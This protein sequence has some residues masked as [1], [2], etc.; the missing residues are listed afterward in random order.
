LIPIAVILLLLFGIAAV[1]VLFKQ[2]IVPGGFI[3]ECGACKYTLVGLPEG[4][5][6]PECGGRTL[7]RLPDRKEWVVTPV[8]QSVLWTSFA[9]L[10][11]AAAAFHSCGTYLQMLSYRREGFSEITARHMVLHVGRDEPSGTIVTLALFLPLTL[12][13]TCTP[14]IA[15]V[16]SHSKSWRMW[17]LLLLSALIGSALIALAYGWRGTSVLQK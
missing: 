14:L 5:V 15:I 11:V 1:C 12:F 6:C 16:E 3:P 4:S 2:R 9:L 17:R 8:H 7:T 13:L 10:F